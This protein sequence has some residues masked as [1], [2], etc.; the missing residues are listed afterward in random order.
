M[1]VRATLADVAALA[2]VHPSTVSRALNHPQL[3]APATR[4]RVQA[5]AAEL[6]FTPN[7][8]AQGLL[9]GRTGAVAM[10]VP[11]I[12][13]PYFAAL[14]QAAQ[15]AASA[16]GLVLII[17]ET[18][19]DEVEEA[20]VLDLLRARV[21]GVIC[22]SPVLDRPPTGAPPVVHVNRRTAGV[23]A[24]T[25]DQRAVVG[26]AREHLEGLAHD[27][28]A[29]L[30]GP[31]GYWST[32]ERRAALDAT[33]ALRPHDVVLVDVDPDFDGGFGMVDRVLDTGATAVVAFN[34]LMALGVLAG[35]AAAGRRVPEDI[36]VVGSDDVRAAAM[37]W[38]PL[39][40][41]TGRLDDVGRSAVALVGAL[42]DGDRPSD[43]SLEPALV[44]RRSTAPPGR[45]T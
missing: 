29:W 24:V 44:A 30:L 26:L 43:V 17:A 36:S 19:H 12:A 39:T 11:D 9:R 8:L 42:L 4:D 13:N 6:S 34:D 1:N 14:A 3:V 20:R 5:A 33:T 16:R 40:T 35:L 38:P 22:C 2:G 21:D 23:P 10:L 18:R 25:I 28:I 41:V 31:E 32:G 7:P 27:R 37:S 45:S 15:A